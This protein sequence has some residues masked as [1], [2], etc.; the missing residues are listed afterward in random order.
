MPHGSTLKMLCFVRPA[1]TGTDT[2]RFHSDE[3]L[4]AAG[5]TE[6]EE[7]LEN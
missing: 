2:A 4:G 7:R 6:T 5:A 3:V 1:D